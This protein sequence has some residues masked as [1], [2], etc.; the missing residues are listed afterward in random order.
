MPERDEAE[1]RDEEF[2]RTVE[3]KVARKRRARFEDHNIWFGLGMFGMVGW[4]VA[5]PTLAGIALGLWLDHRYPLGS[6]SWTLTLL[7]VG[8]TIGCL[9]AWQWIRR[10][11]GR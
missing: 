10:E 9:I 8:V 2:E 6:V 1:R 4:S 11:S 3:S 7:V 5:L